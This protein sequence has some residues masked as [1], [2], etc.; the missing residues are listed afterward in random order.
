[1]DKP[2]QLRLTSNEL[3]ELPAPIRFALFADATNGR[4]EVFLALLVNQMQRVL[5]AS[6]F[7]VNNHLC[8]PSRQSR[9]INFV[10]KNWTTTPHQTGG[11]KQSS[12]SKRH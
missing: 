2:F 12:R 1:V 5:S 11:T 6:L 8:I 4:R 7:T 9:S 3:P 10:G